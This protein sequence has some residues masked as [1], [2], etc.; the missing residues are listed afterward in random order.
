MKSELLEKWK[1]KHPE[2]KL[3]VTKWLQFPEKRD[4]RDLIPPDEIDE[5]YLCKS[6]GYINDFSICQSKNFERLF[7][8]NFGRI[9]D[10]DVNLIVNSLL[11]VQKTYFNFKINREDMK[12]QYIK[13]M[14]DA[15]IYRFEKYV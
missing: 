7:Y 9:G 11:F 1:R 15:N 13:F 10:Y 3:I 6:C 4:I 5:E 12:K 2:K 8:H 14:E